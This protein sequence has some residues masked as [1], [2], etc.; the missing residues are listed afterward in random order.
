MEL[1]IIVLEILLKRIKVAPRSPTNQLECKVNLLNKEH[2]VQGFAK[3]N[4]EGSRFKK[5]YP[6]TRD[7]LLQRTLNML[8]T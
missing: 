5:S 1:C 6:L 2:P 3:L 4:T 8:V 7:Q